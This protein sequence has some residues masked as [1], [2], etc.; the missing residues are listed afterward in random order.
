MRKS[1][2]A[3]SPITTSTCSVTIKPRAIR[4][5]VEIIRTATNA[6]RAPFGFVDW[7]CFKNT[8]I[9]IISNILDIFRL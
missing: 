9:M 3:I 1:I 2:V 8:Y 7:S 4:S 6:I 5:L